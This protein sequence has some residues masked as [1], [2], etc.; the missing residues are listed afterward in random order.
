[1]NYAVVEPLILVADK[2]RLPVSMYTVGAV[3]I[4]QDLKCFFGGKEVTNISMY[5]Q[6]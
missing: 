5:V 3:C 2:S 1:M 4:A 6:C